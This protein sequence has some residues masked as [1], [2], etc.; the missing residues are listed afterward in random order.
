MKL[1]D[2]TIEIKIRY[3]LDR[4]DI[5]SVRLLTELRIR[6]KLQEYLQHSPGCNG[7]FPTHKCTCGLAK[8]IDE[9]EAL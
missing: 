6:R 7:P 2:E 9:L 3:H 4:G 5:V 8:L 1:N